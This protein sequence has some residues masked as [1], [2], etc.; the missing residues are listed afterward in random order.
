MKIAKAGLSSIQD[1]GRTGYRNFGI[2]TGGAMDRMALRLCNLLVANEPGAAAIE[3]S[4]GPWEATAEE[5]LLLA[6]GGNGQRISAGEKELRCWQPFVLKAG[7]KLRIESPLGGYAILAVHGGFRCVPVLG[8]RS[9]HLSG[10]FGGWN[11]RP[12]AT[13]DDITT[14]QLQTAAAEKIIKQLGGKPGIR[15][16]R[17]SDAVIPNYNR[18]FFRYV[19]AHEADWFEPASVTALHENSFDLT[20][21]SNRTGARLFGEPLQFNTDKQMVST[22]VV[23]GTMQV[24]A[25][26]QILVL[27]ADAQTAGGY[28]RI[29]QLA[30]VDIAILAQQK[31]GATLR[32]KPISRQEAETLCLQQRQ[33]FEQLQRDYSLYFS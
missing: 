10:K 18:E 29:G 8:S 23:P 17:L 12:L 5:P 22:A 11:G 6:V 2:T 28:P 26:G 16:F 4:A 9:T 3:I 24:S 31:P 27:L 30:S 19:P 20:H 25:N 7:D 33:Q 15:A 32:F 1:L 14:T 13:G 21:L